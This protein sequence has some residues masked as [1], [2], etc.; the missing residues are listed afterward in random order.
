MYTILSTAGAEELRES[1]LGELFAE[2]LE[3]SQ[4]II[5]ADSQRVAL[6]DIGAVSCTTFSPSASPRA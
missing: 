6:R 2:T 3:P 5:H 1:N 4:E